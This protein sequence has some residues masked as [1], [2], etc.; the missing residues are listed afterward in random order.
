MNDF[1]DSEYTPRIL[2]ILKSAFYN[3]NPTETRLTEIR[4]YTEIH[5]RRI[6]NLGS[7]SKFMLGDLKFIRNKSLENLGEIRKNELIEIVDIIRKLGN[8]GTHTQY[9]KEFTDS[10]YEKA[11]D[12][13]FDLIAFQFVSYFKK[14]PMRLTSPN[15]VMFDFSLLPPIIRF[16]T[17]N[18][19]LKNDPDNIQILN[20]ITLAR[21]KTFGKTVTYDWLKKNESNFR[22]I[23]YPTEGEINEYIGKC[24]VQISPGIFVF[25]IKLNCFDNVYD[26]L[27]NKIDDSNTS[28]NENGKLY[29]SFESA[30]IYYHKKKHPDSNFEIKELHSIMDFVYI[31]R[32]SQIKI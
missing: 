3:N 21:I 22:S 5:L 2:N 30:I 28:V 1:N 27:K 16:K 26:L 8:D 6:L 14:Y 29:S 19:L 32:K 18:S 20:R 25:S 12:A 24:G 23:Q 13:L 4:K 11:I 9:T 7:D 31:G 10:D 15:D 17:L